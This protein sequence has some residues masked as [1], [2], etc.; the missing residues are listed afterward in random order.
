MLY[1]VNAND[2]FYPSVCRLPILLEKIPDS[3]CILSLICLLYRLNDI[4][5]DRR[6]I[7]GGG[8]SELPKVA[9]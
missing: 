1:P 8:L 3:E 5:D 9:R 6:P 4:V 2:P 7:S